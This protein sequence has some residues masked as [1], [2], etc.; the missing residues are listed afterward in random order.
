MH[1]AGGLHG[2]GGAGVISFVGAGPGAADLITLRGAR[3]LADA[4]VVI[5][6]GSLVPDP[7]LN[8][9]N[10]EATALDSSSMTLEDVI[11]VYESYPA[12]TPI[13]RLHSGDPAFYGAITEQITWCRASGRA[14]EVIPGVSSIGAAAAVLGA[15]LTAPGL[16]QSV[17][18]TRLPARTSASAAPGESLASL[19]VHGLTM[20]VL[21]SG[22][23]PAALQAELLSEGSGYGPS[24]PAAIVVKATWPEETVIRTTLEHLAEEL[25][26]CGAT[27]TVL[28]LV[29]R[30]L[31]P[32]GARSRLYSPE[33]A[34]SYR[35]RSRPGEVSGRPAKRRPGAAGATGGTGE[36]VEPQ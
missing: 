15:E 25:A 8:H 21:L 3:R 18:V 16:S 19:A 12:A 5:W 7:V 29:G 9:A 22:A 28:V 24:T 33:F 14:F 35:R 11:K 1:G 17:I 13:V 6:A 26:A 23:R 4:E 36:V 34:H 31:S 20:A 2:A 10:P 27:T 30:A 32:E